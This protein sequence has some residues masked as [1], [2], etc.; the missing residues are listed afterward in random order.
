[1]YVLMCMY[2]LIQYN[3]CVQLVSRY[4]S[5]IYINSDSLLFTVKIQKGIVMIQKVTDLKL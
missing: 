1:M 5:K 2:L 4:I 3:Y